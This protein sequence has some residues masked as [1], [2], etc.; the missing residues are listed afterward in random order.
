V[1]RYAI[2]PDRSR[3]WIEA[4]SSLHPIHSETTGL[5]GWLEMEIEGGGR[6]NLSV[7]PK[8]LLE[9]PVE[10]LSSGNGL[11]DR[12]MRRRINARR[13]PTMRGELTE[14]KE[15]DGEGRYAVSGDLTF[16]GVTRRV[17]GEITVTAM[18]DQTIRVTGEQVF[19]IQDFD[20]DPPKILTL[21]VYPDVTV[22][23]E[24]IAG[25]D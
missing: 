1:A 23:I 12:E 20:L 3:V 5:D 22:R 6:V 24:I 14:M 25:R 7:P 11:Y 10:M 9:L 16:H 19:D 18:D 21:R 17:E 8:A 4:R 2:D 13:F 15:L